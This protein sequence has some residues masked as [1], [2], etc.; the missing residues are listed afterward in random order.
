[1]PK[2]LEHPVVALETSFDSVNGQDY[3]DYMRSRKRAA[4]GSDQETDEERKK[5]FFAA[6][7]MKN[8]IDHCLICH[9]FKLNDTQMCN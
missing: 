1:M 7:C 9:E 2:N 6:L 4:K 8:E 5:R 3:E